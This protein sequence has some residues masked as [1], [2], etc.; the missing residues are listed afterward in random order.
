MKVSDFGRSF[1]VGFRL[2]SIY[3]VRERPD[4][5]SDFGWIR[6]FYVLRFCCS[7]SVSSAWCKVPTESGNN[8]GTVRGLCKC[9]PCRG[10]NCFGGF[11]NPPMGW[12]PLDHKFAWRRDRNPVYEA[13]QYGVET[14]DAFAI[15][16]SVQGPQLKSGE[17][18]CA[19]RR[20]NSLKLLYYNL[21]LLGCKWVKCNG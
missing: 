19:S 1:L 3:L 14:G 21:L 20:T 12:L 4:L 6:F 13:N 11:S 7:L 15:I 8:P 9:A 5:N 18:A 17:R 16:Q 2:L 10:G